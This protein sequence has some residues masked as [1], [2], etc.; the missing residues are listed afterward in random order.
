MNI[1]EFTKVEILTKE[2]VSF[3]FINIRQII[4]KENLNSEFSKILFF[5]NWLVHSQLN[6]KNTTEL[7]LL[8][9]RKA[10]VEHFNE[11]TEI[12][13]EL[14]KIINTPKLKKELLTFLK[15]FDIDAG[16][17]KNTARI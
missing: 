17:L 14:S 6:W 8:E 5:S 10:I 9:M 7:V 13:N 11:Q 2:N 3:F 1:S 12:A 15:K 16:F 4:E